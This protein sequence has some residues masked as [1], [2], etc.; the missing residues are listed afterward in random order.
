MKVKVL[1]S[2]WD[3]FMERL[4]PKQPENSHR[5]H[6]LKKLLIEKSIVL[7]PPSTTALF[8]LKPTHLSEAGIVRIQLSAEVC[9]V[10]WRSWILNSN[11]E[12]A[13][14][15]RLSTSTILHFL[16]TGVF[17]I[18]NDNGQVSSAVRL[19]AQSR[20]PHPVFAPGTLP[21][22]ASPPFRKSTSMEYFSVALPL[23][24]NCPSDQSQESV[25]LPPPTNRPPSTQSLE[26]QE[27]FV[28]LPPPETDSPPDQ[29]L[30]LHEC[31]YCTKRET[32]LLE[33]NSQLQKIVK[34][35]GHK[36]ELLKKEMKETDCGIFQMLDVI[37]IAESHA[38]KWESVCND[39]LM[40]VESLNSRIDDLRRDLSKRDENDHSFLTEQQRLQELILLMRDKRKQF[41]NALSLAEYL[42][43]FVA[44]GEFEIKKRRKRIDELALKGRRRRERLSEYESLVLLYGDNLDHL[45]LAKLMKNTLNWQKQVKNTVVGREIVKETKRDLIKLLKLTPDESWD[46]QIKSGLSDEQLDKVRL[47]LGQKRDGFERLLSCSRS[48]QKIRNAEQS[49]L[50]ARLKRKRTKS[51]GTMISLREAMRL[52]TD[53]YGIT[54]EK[55]TIYKWK[56]G[57]DGRKI[58]K[59]DQVMCGITP[60]DFGLAV[61]SCYNTL[62]VAIVCGKED[63]DF[64]LE[65]WKELFEEIKELNETGFLSITPPKDPELPETPITD[66]A[67]EVLVPDD[68]GSKTTITDD[69]SELP[70]TTITDDNPEPLAHISQ[71]QAVISPPQDAP[72]PTPR[73]FLPPPSQ[74][75]ST[76]PSTPPLIIRVPPITDDGPLMSDKVEKTTLKRSENKKRPRDKVMRLKFIIV[77]DLSSCWVVYRFGGAKV[78]GNCIYCDVG[79]PADR[80]DMNLKWET[81][82]RK[83]KLE[84]VFGTGDKDFVFCTLHLLLRV[85]EFFM[86]WVYEKVD[87]HKHFD[88]LC[89]V[90]SEDVHVGFKVYEDHIRGGMR[91]KSYNGGQCSKILSQIEKIT[92]LVD[93]AEHNFATKVWI[94]FRRMFEDIQVGE[95]HDNQGRIVSKESWKERALVWGKLFVKVHGRKYARI[96]IHILIYHAADIVEEFGP[97]GVLSQQGFEAANALQSALGCHHSDHHWGES[98]KAGSNLNAFDEVLGR[99]WMLKNHVQTEQAK[100]K[101]KGC[102]SIGKEDNV[103]EPSGCG[104]FLAHK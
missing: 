17:M 53:L 59:M 69:A 61:Q 24:A 12:A 15:C 20:L 76:P 25:A 67:P 83:V 48:T 104:W 100:K 96:Y 44:G 32:E 41:D 52:L 46:L 3:C 28:S 88:K 47:V 29:S 70:K 98:A 77:T 56:L 58:A 21:Q 94:E 26:L 38:N 50:F 5:A 87:E 86:Q 91:V 74:Q 4:E 73:F 90:M 37:Q 64:L 84:S 68:V 75:P 80:A 97:L 49:S 103:Q 82:S 14:I 19:G 18:R 99:C 34:T 66:D 51:G 36:I 55:D 31:T 65:E 62:P 1:Q 16:G 72:W 43:E 85:I 63:V 40:E 89:R 23:P 79:S 6:T 11:L 27:Q 60:L 10:L 95:F 33:E 93:D 92:P 9:E 57:I 35:Q 7:L 101:K 78:H 42:E 54:G 13:P 39:L 71:Q 30:Q 8:P 2:V 102:A 45:V 81:W 22:V